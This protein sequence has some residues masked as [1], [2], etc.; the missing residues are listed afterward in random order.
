MKRETDGKIEIAPLLPHA[1]GAPKINATPV[2]GASPGKE[3]FYAV[4]VRGE[5]PLRFRVSGRLPRGIVFSPETGWFQG[6]ALEAGEFPV[7]LSAEN[8]L[9]RD[10]KPFRI[11]IGE[12][13]ICLTPL[14]GWTSWNACTMNVTDELVR[15][16]ASALVEK[17]LAARGYSYINIDSCWQGARDPVTNAIQGN[18]NFPDMK[19]LAAYIHS[20][21]LKA[22]IYSTPMVHAWGSTPD[23]LLPGSTGYPLDPRHFHGYFGGCGMC[24]FEENDA[25][26]W[27]EWKFDYLKYD[28]P[29]CDEEHTRKISEALRKTDRDFVLSLTTSCKLEWIDTYRKCANMYRSN[30]DTV[31]TW[32]RL[33]ANA[34]QA[35]AWAPHIAPGNWFDMD[36]LA[37]GRMTIGRTSSDFR[38]TALRENRLSRNERIT[39]VSMWALF[40]SPIQISC[41]LASIDDLTLALL[42]NEE[43]LALNQD[44]LGCGAICIQEDLR[45][46][47]D[48]SILRHGKIYR[49]RL[50][51]NAE[52]FGFFNLGENTETFSCPIPSSRRTVRDLWAQRDLAVSGGTLS[53]DIPPHGCR[54][55]RLS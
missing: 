13:R 19:G 47:A 10:E 5:R 24:G 3:F 41:D 18:C 15:R 36:M 46:D 34:F 38:E 53:F 2:F 35:D 14:L 48:G 21:G 52:A 16:N 22:G 11:V 44:E 1:A 27:A 42:S 43:I 50:A 51:G 49:R 28:W 54:I 40:P 12:N 55:V 26:Q 20:L 23:R 4:P 31:D 45:R 30:N 8:A 33:S 37:L 7:V 32:E 9:G 25:R 29:S 6:R 39:H 17:G